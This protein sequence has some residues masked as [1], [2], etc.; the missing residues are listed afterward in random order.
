MNI[1]LDRL[2]SRTDRKL[3]AELD[4]VKFGKMR[5]ECVCV[6][7]GNKRPVGKGKEA[8]IACLNSAEMALSLYIKS[9]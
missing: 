5:L 4:K 1:Q 9:G 8:N 7:V 3:I 2:R 6:C